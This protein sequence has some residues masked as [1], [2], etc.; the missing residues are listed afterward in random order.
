VQDNEIFRNG[1]GKPIVA[2]DIDGSL[3]NYHAWFLKFAELYFDKPMP[4]V[5]NI[6]PGLPLHR[7]MGVK[8]KDYRDCKLA[9][10]QGGMKRSMPMYEG[11]DLL[12]EALHHCGAE[13]WIC[14]TR[15]YLRLD[16]IDPDTREWLRRN[17]IEYDAVIFGDD[18]YEELVRQVPIYRIV[19]IVDD[20]PEQVDKAYAAGVAKIYLRDQPYNSA[21]TLSAFTNQAYTRFTN[22]W[23]LQKMLVKDINDWKATYE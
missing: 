7:F 1:A 11:A 14:T 2:L 5:D 22:C 6:N 19:A 20:L 13:I 4:P 12:T 3:A 9:Y 10:R 21:D 16:N 18:K 17:H 15:P 8:L 23:E